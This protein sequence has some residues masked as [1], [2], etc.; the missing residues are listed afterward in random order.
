[1]DCELSP[2]QMEKALKLC[3]ILGLD[4]FTVATVL[5]EQAQWNL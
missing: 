4:D 1:M 3:D 5:L 2:E